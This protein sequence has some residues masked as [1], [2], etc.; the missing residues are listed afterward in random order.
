MSFWP[1]P[2]K[3]AQHVAAQATVNDNELAAIGYG[4]ILDRDQRAPAHIRLV[5]R[6]VD[7]RKSSDAEY[8]SLSRGR[9]RSYRE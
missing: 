9:H 4:K 7:K 3:E 2:T 1:N 5:M 8:S 6:T